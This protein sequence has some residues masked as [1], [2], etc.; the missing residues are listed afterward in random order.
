MLKIGKMSAKERK[1]RERA[2]E[3]K[4]WDENQKPGQGVCLGQTRTNRE[5]VQFSSVPLT[6]SCLGKRDAARAC[7]CSCKPT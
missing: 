5:P 1:Q 6:P 3:R 7:V 2:K 4:H